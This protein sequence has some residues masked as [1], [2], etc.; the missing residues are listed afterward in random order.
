MELIGKL[1]GSNTTKNG[2]LPSA[3]KD[4]SV[5]FVDQ[6]LHIFNSKEI[7]NGM[8]SSTKMQKRE[9]LFKYL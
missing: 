9:G 8:K 3:S 7:L 6:C 5:K 2:M 1:G 4:V